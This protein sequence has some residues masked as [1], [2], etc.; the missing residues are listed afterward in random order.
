[1]LHKY[2]IELESS[3]PALAWQGQFHYGVTAYNYEDAL[4][5]LVERFCMNRDFPSVVSVVE[6]V[7]ISTLQV[8]KLVTE[9]G[10]PV[11]RGIWYPY[12]DYLR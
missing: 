11:W 5:L 2:W 6:D 8:G 3:D 1:M 10:V 9:I 4:K 12:F 7:D